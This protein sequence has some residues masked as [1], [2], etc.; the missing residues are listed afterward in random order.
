MEL[1]GSLI[2]STEKM[3]EGNVSL[4]FSNPSSERAKI[5]QMEDSIEKASKRQKLCFEKTSSHIDSI[6]SELK[7]CKSSLENC[8]FLF[9]SF[10]FLIQKNYNFKF[11]VQNLLNSSKMEVEGT[12]E[13]SNSNSN[14]FFSSQENKP[15]KRTSSEE[16]QKY[17][18]QCVGNLVK[19]V[20][21]SDIPNK[22][23]KEHKE[24]HVA[25]SKIGKNID[26]FTPSEISSV[27]NP[28]LAFD[29]NQLNYFVAEHLFREGS[30][31]LAEMFSKV[32]ILVNFL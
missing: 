29:K 2:E 15:E 22:V 6:I 24:V 25:I 10:L 4:T 31:Q 16:E 27:Y 9:F 1:S 3:N 18:R 20:K 7:K 19:K 26:K 8:E 21:E 30:F 14:S 13:N 5:E 32:I 28:S 23:S 11:I 17:I 12:N